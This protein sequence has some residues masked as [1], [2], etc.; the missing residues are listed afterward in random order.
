MRGG[1]E[2][3]RGESNFPFRLNF[4]TP[5]RVC[6]R[7]ADWDGSPWEF[8]GGEGDRKCLNSLPIPNLSPFAPMR[9]KLGKTL[10]FKGLPAYHGES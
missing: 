6:V 10:N 9:V 5:P 4:M 3:E 2:R 1:E 8:R 7:I